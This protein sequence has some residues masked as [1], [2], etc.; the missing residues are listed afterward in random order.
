MEQVMQK[1]ESLEDCYSH[2]RT[3]ENSKFIDGALYALG[4]VKGILKKEQEARGEGE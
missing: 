4:I 2:S 3:E 1:V